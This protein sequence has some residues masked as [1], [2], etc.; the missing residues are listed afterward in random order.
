MARVACYLLGIVVC[1]SLMP[2]QIILHKHLH[3]SLGILL[4]IFQFFVGLALIHLGT[5]GLND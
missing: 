4:G 2:L 5:W 1:I 3:I